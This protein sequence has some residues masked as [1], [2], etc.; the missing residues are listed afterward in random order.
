M[1]KTLRLQVSII[2]LM[3][4][5]L[6][7]AAACGADPTPTAA[8]TP[9]PTAALTPTPTAAPTPTPTAA[10]TPVSTAAPTLTATP[11]LS[12]DDLLSSAGAK[13][14]A[15]STAKFQ[16]VDELESGTKFFGTTFKRLEGEVKTP[17]SFRMR[18]DVVSPGFGFVEIGMMAIG[19]QA[20]I[21][22]S[23]DAPWVPLPLEQVP[24]DFGG[25]GV[26]LSEL[27]PNIKDAAIV[28]QESL[29]GTQT[30][31]VEGNVTSEDLLDVIKSVGS[32]HAVILTLW[33]EDDRHILQ[34]MRIGGQ[35]FD[36]DA[37]ETTRLLTIEGIDIPVDIQLPDIASG[38]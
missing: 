17:D 7:L 24:F 20:Y 18:V 37:P 22:F 33:I 13:L 15:M 35:I 8:L 26:A 2:M 14:A 4:G 38:P 23:E 5:V 12:V 1:S 16:L 3:M 31:R 36:D 6:L 32:G 34:Q 27:L 28:G 25:I 11:Q 10:P 29:G 21:Q 30:I 9:T 19:D